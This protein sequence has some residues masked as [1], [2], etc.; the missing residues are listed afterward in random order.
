MINLYDVVH[1][2]VY[3]NVWEIVICSNEYVQGYMGTLNSYFVGNPIGR[4]RIIITL[5]TESI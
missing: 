3:A 2:D 1:N 4:A 5:I